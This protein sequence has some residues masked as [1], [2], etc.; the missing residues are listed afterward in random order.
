MF[1]Q[2]NI[3]S[4][5]GTLIIESTVSPRIDFLKTEAKYIP[6][7]QTNEQKTQ[8]DLIALEKKIREIES[9]G[10]KP[11]QSSKSKKIIQKSRLTT[12]EETPVDQKQTNCLDEK[13]NLNHPKAISTHSLHEEVR[14]LS[15][16]EF[17]LKSFKSPKLNRNI[18]SDLS[19][20]SGKKKEENEE[21][22]RRKTGKA[23]TGNGNS[24]VYLN[25]SGDCFKNESQTNR[26]L[27]LSFEQNDNETP[28]VTPGVSMDK[29]RQRDS[30]KEGKIALLRIGES[31]NNV[32]E[33][34]GTDDRME[35]SEN[36]K[37]FVKSSDYN[38]II[39]K[40]SEES[41]SH[42]FGEESSPTCAVCFD[43]SP[44]AVFMS[45]GHGG[46]CYECAKDLWKG[47]DECYLC[48]SVSHH[49][50]TCFSK[51]ETNS[52][53]NLIGFPLFD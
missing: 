4:F 41:K 5:K 43:K 38:I 23:Q 10:T 40:S 48:R 29:P 3:S 37:E 50:L 31:P 49:P 46:I 42:D 22:S 7:P 1:S 32:T 47:K 26:K 33:R 6:N 36:K 39:E 11:N 12:G 28:E 20:S 34:T 14:K 30:I 19:M 53:F 24:V 17:S 51:L 52:M 35:R 21:V 27:I 25:V 13:P 44:N 45:C 18:Q 9:S 16:L 15:T 8:G 2:S